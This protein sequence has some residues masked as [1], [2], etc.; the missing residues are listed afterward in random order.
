MA[1][2]GRQI[3]FPFVVFV[4]FKDGL[5]A[6]ERFVYDMAGLLRQLR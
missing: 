2:T 1:P 3:R 6:G 5:L 4:T